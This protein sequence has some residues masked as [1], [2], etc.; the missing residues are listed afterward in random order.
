MEKFTKSSILRDSHEILKVTNLSKSY[1]N[2]KVL[3]EINLNV[4]YGESVAL[5]GSNGS[6]KST[7]IKCLLGLTNIEKG[8]IYTNQ[9]R[10]NMKNNNLLKFYRRD[11]AFIW[12][13]HNLVPRLSVLSNVIHGSLNSHPNPRLWYQAFAPSEIR[14]RALNCLDQ[15]GLKNFAKNNVNTLS[16]GESQ[17]VAIARA[18]MQ[19]P[20]LMIADEPVASLDPKVGIEVMNLL[21]DLTLKQG[22][23][24]FFTTHDLKHAE[25]YA[26]RVIGLKD[27]VIKINIKSKELNELDVDEFYAA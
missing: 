19:K 2:K 8:E 7:L 16:G 23:T 22:I 1:K 18:L 6:G 15:V 5:I 13:T 26:N 3:R 14:S 9:I 21:K 12:Q 20:K 25:H 4:S 27:G 17:R 24:L 10:L 11:I